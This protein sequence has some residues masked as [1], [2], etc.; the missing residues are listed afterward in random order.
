MVIGKEFFLFDI[1]VLD[2]TM[3]PHDPYYG[4]RPVAKVTNS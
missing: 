1:K 2:G 4:L 3:T